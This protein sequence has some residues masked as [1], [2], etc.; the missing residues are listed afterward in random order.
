VDSVAAVRNYAFDDTQGYGTR[1]SMTL[2]MLD[3]VIASSGP[4][5]MN[6]VE[7]QISQTQVDV[8]ATDAGVAATAK[9]LRHI[10][11][12]TNANLTFT[13]GLV[14]LEDVHYNA[15]K[16]TLMMGTPASTSQREHTFSWD[17]VA[18]DG[19]FTDR[20]FAYDAP[21]NTTPGANGSQ[22]LGQFSMA[23]QTS[24]WNVPD[25]P[26][27]PQAAA[28]RVLFD[29]NGENNPDPTVINVIVNGHAHSVPW[30]YPDQL[31]Y[32]WRTLAVTVPLTDL[33][34]GTNKVQLGADTAQVF[35]NVDIVLGDVTGGIPVLP[36]ANDAYP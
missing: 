36:G 23:N 9:T 35:A 16:E 1:T 17:N 19:P 7:I 3:C 21:D 33:V 20:D 6:H 15:D 34:A 29:F 32:S 5:N 4:G 22:N 14:W 8:Y 12:I 25:L 18:F 10:A 31:K 11:T 28:A 26:A 27:N 24:T 13:R 30:P 2:T